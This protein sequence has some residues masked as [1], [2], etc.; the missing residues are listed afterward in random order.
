MGLVLLI[1]AIALWRRAEGN[2]TAL[3]ARRDTLE[4]E[5]QR[6]AR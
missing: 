6:G 5:L 1:V 4:R 3:A 2:Y